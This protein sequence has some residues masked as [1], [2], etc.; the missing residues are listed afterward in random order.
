[1]AGL[2]ADSRADALRSCSERFQALRSAWG[3][4]APS[5]IF[6]ENQVSAETGRA[7]SESLTRLLRDEDTGDDPT[8]VAALETRLDELER[9]MRDVSLEVPV[10]QLRSTLPERIAVDRRGVL[11]LLDLI[12]GAELSGREGTRARIPTLD[13]LITLLCTGGDPDAPLQDP[14]GLTPKLHL[15]CQRA[16]ADCRLDV[17]KLEAEFHAASEPGKA[18]VRQEV[19]RRTLRRRKMELDQAFFVPRVLRAIVGYNAALLRRIA[20]EVLSAQDWGT[21]PG[22]EA[23]SEGVSVFES[24]PLPKLAAALRRRAADEPPAHDPLDRIAWCLDLGCLSGQERDAL[25]SQGTGRREELIG[26]TVLVGLLRRS[27]VVLDEEF[28][29]IGIAPEQLSDAWTQELENVLQQEVNQRIASEGCGLSFVLT[30]LR[31]NFLSTTP[32]GKRPRRIRGLATPA[33]PTRYQ[34]RARAPQESPRQQAKQLTSEALDSLGRGGAKRD[35]RGGAWRRLAGLGA[36]GILAV[37]ALALVNHV[38][39]SEGRVARTE[40]EE[41]SPHL[42]Q[43]RR[44]ADGIGTAFAGTLDD[45]WSEL[46]PAA[47]AE[48]AQ[49]LVAGLRERGVREIMIFDADRRLRIQALGNQPPTLVPAALP[50]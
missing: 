20:E 40:L 1:M 6:G 46:A 42:A 37:A 33:A 45:G 39:W 50:R 27:A 10:A 32:S 26:T 41:L 43:G 48:A 14:A 17:A 21:V 30:D 47:Q 22:A 2:A 36:A 24:E 7:L 49:V 12:L 11:D 28:P 3:A 4:L 13:Y 15:L 38:L 35:E 19:M 31:G 29:T 8:A 44:S 9:E 18:N 5:G 34:N 25:L 23:P 16:E